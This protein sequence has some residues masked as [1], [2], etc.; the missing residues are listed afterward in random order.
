MEA[1]NEKKEKKGKRFVKSIVFGVAA[2]G[3]GFVAGMF[4]KEIGAGVKTVV[5]KVKNRNNKPNVEKT[6]D[7]KV[8]QKPQ[9]PVSAERGQDNRGGNWNNRNRI[10]K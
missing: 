8:D 2:I 9:Q 10:N 7:V 5:D 4:R 6:M 3:L 1:K